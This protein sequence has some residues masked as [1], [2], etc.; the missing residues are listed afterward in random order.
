[1]DERY[2]KPGNKDATLLIVDDD[3]E[4]CHAL[5]KLISTWGMQTASVTSAFEALD[6]VR[7][8]FFNIILLDVIMPK[9]SGTDS[10]PEIAELCPD[11]KII[12]MTGYAD[13]D[14]VIE[15][16]RLGAFDFLEKPIGF[17]LLSHSI[18][19]A[20]EMQRTAWQ[21]KKAYEDLK[22]SRD[23]LLVYKSSLQRVNKQLMENNN[24]LS[25]LA[26]NIDITRKETA[27]GIIL[28]IRSLIIP[29]LEKLQQD[30]KLA[31]YHAE[32]N[33]L[34]LHLENF[35]SD[36]ASDLK[37]VTFL[38]VSELRIAS[39]IKNGLATN[40][41]AQ[42]LYISPSTVK[43]H[44]RNIRKKLKI[45]NTHCSLKDYLRVETKSELAGQGQK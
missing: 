25:V 27:K 36:L 35:T 28:E 43:T 10:I 23:D 7:D 37:I 45:C 30:R 34:M 3:P 39:L 18:N 12:I 11:A 33:T 4:I 2:M 9:K 32:L 26:K 40:E 16:L 14:T 15:A 13:K 41:I 8:T 38:T 24:A 5:E 21:S 6:Q 42:Y 31:Q 29:L 17:P 22:C 20:L 1:M 19:R 44:R